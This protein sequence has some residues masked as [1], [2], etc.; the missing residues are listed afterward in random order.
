VLAPLLGIVG[1]IQ[2]AEAMKL[3]VGMGETLVGRVMVLDALDME[4]RTLR[5]RKDPQCPVC[6]R[7]HSA[8]A[9]AAARG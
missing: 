6:A 5:L 8:D 1:S 9:S 7:P 4:L 3:I 2:A